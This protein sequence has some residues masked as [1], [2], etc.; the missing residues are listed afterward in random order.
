MQDSPERNHDDIDERFDE[1]PLVASALVPRPAA[2]GAPSALS[3]EMASLELEAEDESAGQLS[4]T[5]L[6]R[7]KWLILGTFVL[8]SLIAIPPIWVFVVP[9]YGATA[10]IRVR[11]VQPKLIYD[12]NDEGTTNRNFGVYFNTLMAQFTNP[13][14]LQRVLVR[15]DVQNSHWYGDDPQTLRTMLGAEPPSRISRLRLAITAENR[16]DTELLDVEMLATEALDAQTIVNALVE[17]FMRFTAETTEESDERMFDTLQAQQAELESKMALFIEAKG[18]LSKQL[19][20]DDPDIVRAQLVAQVGELEMER[21]RVHRDYEMNLGEL[22]SREATRDGE[23][24]VAANEEAT[25]RYAQD[26]TWVRL[27]NGMEDALHALDMA[28][29]RY[30]EAHPELKVRVADVEHARRLLEQREGQMGSAW[31]PPNE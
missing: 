1:E 6:M 11:P 12:M 22:A 17:E 28:K 30:G 4:F 9:K 25:F 24:E 18:N 29:A 3:T 8:I 14:I 10:T 27:N 15:D 31:Q 5:G 21:H 16:K 20:T 2:G 23:P 7:A 13:T 26:A 19:G